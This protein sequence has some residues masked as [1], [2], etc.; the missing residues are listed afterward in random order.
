MSMATKQP[1]AT[2]SAASDPAVDGIIEKPKR[3]RAKKPSVKHTPA[4]LAKDWVFPLGTG[5]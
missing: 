1:K 2:P 4:V 5:M 3:N